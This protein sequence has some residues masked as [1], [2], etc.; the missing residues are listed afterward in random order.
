MTL[1]LHRLH[2]FAQL[3][4]GISTRIPLELGLAQGAAQVIH[5]PLVLDGYLCPV[6]VDPVPTDGI[7]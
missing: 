6:A 5:V 7:S 2:L 1:V 3:G 4:P